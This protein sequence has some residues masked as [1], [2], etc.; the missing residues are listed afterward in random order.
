MKQS[1]ASVWKK[2]RA[3]TDSYTSDDAAKHNGRTVAEQSHPGWSFG[4]PPNRHRN[5]DSL[6]G[7]EQRGKGFRLRS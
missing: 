4:L 5:H 6:P 1:A 7:R 3:V 2:H